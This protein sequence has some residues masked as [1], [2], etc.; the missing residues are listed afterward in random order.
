MRRQALLRPST[1]AAAQAGGL[2]PISRA[3]PDRVFGAPAQLGAV[4]DAV[5]A[6]VLQGELF[7]HLSGIK[8][9]TMVLCERT[10]DELK[11]FTTTVELNV[12]VTKLRFD[13]RQEIGLQIQALE[14]AMELPAADVEA[15]EDGVDAEY[16]EAVDEEEDEDAA[17]RPQSRPRMEDEQL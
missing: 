12:W 16:E 5:H 4:G 15:A 17:L 11:G 6:A 14:A 1:S 13:L 7:E 10:W 8:T 2:L 3:P 9:E